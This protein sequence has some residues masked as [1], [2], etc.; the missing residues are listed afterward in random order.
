VNLEGS[1][2]PEEPSETLATGSE[3]PGTAPEQQI[4]TAPEQQ[5]RRAIAA[6]LG[7][8][9]V[10]DVEGARAVLRELLARQGASSGA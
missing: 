8:L 1:E 10:E 9:E 2:E 6:A 7:L 5:I 4:G 3:H